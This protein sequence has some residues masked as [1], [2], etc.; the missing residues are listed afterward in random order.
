M[1]REI[2]FRAWNPTTFWLSEPFNLYDFRGGNTT[3]HISRYGETAVFLQFTG[4]KDKN[5]VDI[6]EGDIVR[7]NSY[8]YQHMNNELWEV[9]Y[10]GEYM[11]FKF[12]MISNEN[13]AY[14]DVH[15]WHSFEV[16]GNIFQNPELIKQ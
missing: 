5:G 1:N 6:Y 3:N 2:K 7:M 11:M 13:G 10:F 4:L 15:G 16:T 9:V 14:E 12:K 8:N